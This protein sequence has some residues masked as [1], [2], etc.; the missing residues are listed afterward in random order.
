MTNRI[1]KEFS[2]YLQDLEELSLGGKSQEYNKDFSHKGLMYLN[3]SI[4][5]LKKV[6]FEY[7]TKIGKKA[8][9]VLSH[10]FADTL[11]E[12]SIVR[13]CLEECAKIDDEAMRMLAPCKYLKRITIIYTRKFGEDVINLISVS[14]P[15]LEYLNLRECLIQCNFSVLGETCLNLAEINLSGD[16]WIKCESIFTMKNIQSLRTLHI[17]TCHI[18][19]SIGHLE[20]GDTQCD[21]LDLNNPTEGLFLLKMLA[22]PNSFVCL[23]SLYL[24]Q[25]C[26]LTNWVVP[27]LHE[28]REKLGMRPVKILYNRGENKWLADTKLLF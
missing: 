19:N 26:Q 21:E 12:I 8:I 24:E 15:K 2:V 28:K 5:H 6:N 25:T 17:G 4:I 11:Q 14:F 10:L 23:D 7:C 1:F 18:L 13:N 16:S 27:K 9:G 3:E 22:D 20:H